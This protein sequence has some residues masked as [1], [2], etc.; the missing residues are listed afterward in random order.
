MVHN[1][2]MRGTNEPEFLFVVFGAMSMAILA[3]AVY[4]FARRRL[5]L[6]VGK[7]FTSIGLAGVSYLNWIRIEV[8]WSTKMRDALITG[9]AM[10][11]GSGLVGVAVLIRDAKKRA[12]LAPHR[13][14]EPESNISNWGE[15]M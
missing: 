6:G 10:L 1:V 7:L 3:M 14:D 4:W 12:L 15:P 2:G 11:V 9:A 13:P 5:G 8:A